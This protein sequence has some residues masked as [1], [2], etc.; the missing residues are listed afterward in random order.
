MDQPQRN[1]V[2]RVRRRRRPVARDIVAV[3]SSVLTHSLQLGRGGAKPPG[4]HIGEWPGV[5][6]W[7]PENPH[8]YDLVVTLGA[9]DGSIVDRV[10]SYAE[11]DLERIRAAT[12]ATG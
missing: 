7:S 4:P 11:V 1:L 5:A 2:V 10:E 8:L 12:L 3:D 6:L 9:A